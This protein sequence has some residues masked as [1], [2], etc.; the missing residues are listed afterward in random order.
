MALFFWRQWVNTNPAQD[1]LGL[2]VSDGDDFDVVSRWM[3]GLLTTSRRLVPS[4]GRPASLRPIRFRQ[5]DRLFQINASI[6]TL[7]DSGVVLGARYQKPDGSPTE[8][9][10]FFMQGPAGFCVVPYYKGTIEQD[11]Q[12][13]RGTHKQPVGVSQPLPPSQSLRVSTD[14]RTI[15]FTKCIG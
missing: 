3:E 5:E 4:S 8:D 13:Y 11:L 1:T 14:C 6:P 2:V 15:T 10:F 7:R 9:C 12:E